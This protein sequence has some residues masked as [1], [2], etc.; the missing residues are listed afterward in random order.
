MESY[1]FGFSKLVPMLIYMI[2]QDEYESRLARAL[3]ELRGEF[4]EKSMLEIKKIARMYQQLNFAMI[5]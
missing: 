2:E 1:R 4:N 5:V 3:E